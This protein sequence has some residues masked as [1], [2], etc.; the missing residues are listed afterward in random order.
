GNSHQCSLNGYECTIRLYARI[1][2][3]RKNN[4]LGRKVGKQQT[5]KEKKGI[6]YSMEE[7]IETHDGDPPV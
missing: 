2:M 1:D 6:K 4:S 3:P 5:Y 7:I